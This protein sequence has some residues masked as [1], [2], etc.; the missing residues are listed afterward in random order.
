[1]GEGDGRGKEDW[2]EWMS[3]DDRNE[4]AWGSDGCVMV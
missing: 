3:Q 1:M 4:R 2:R